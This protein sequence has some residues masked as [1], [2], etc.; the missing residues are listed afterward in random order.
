MRERLR[1]YIRKCMKDA[2]ETGAPV[3]RPM[4]YDFPDDEKC[5]V[6]TDQYMFGPDLLMAPVMEEGM[7]GS[8]VYL[9]HYHQW[10]DAKS[11]KVYDGGTT[12]IVDTPI[13]V[14]PVFVKD[15]ADISVWE[16]RREK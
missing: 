9:P 11:G 16:N 12:V 2:S 1:P 6:M 4:Y 8:S 15:S 14:I 5:A 7:K 3:A 13:D 10:K